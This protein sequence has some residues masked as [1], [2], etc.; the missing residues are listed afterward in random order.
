M[1]SEHRDLAAARCFLRSAKAVT[2]VAPDRV[3]TDGL[4]PYYLGRSEQCSANMCGIERC[5]NLTDI[6]DKRFLRAFLLFC[7]AGDTAFLPRP[8]RCGG[9]ARSARRGWR[10]ADRHVL[11]GRERGATLRQVG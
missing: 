2:G 6:F 8:E 7:S 5:R 3:T 10:K 11:D 4:D 9:A 1:L